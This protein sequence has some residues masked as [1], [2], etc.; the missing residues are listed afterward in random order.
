MGCSEIFFRLSADRDTDNFITLF[1]Q[2]KALNTNTKYVSSD[3][4]LN[5]E[6]VSK[7]G[8]KFRLQ[9]A[10]R[11]NRANQTFGKTKNGVRRLAFSDE[12]KSYTTRLNV[13]QK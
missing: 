7:L 6:R 13:Y 3:W 10:I 2:D 8:G 5:D 9:K 4:S 11:N 12:N 1:L